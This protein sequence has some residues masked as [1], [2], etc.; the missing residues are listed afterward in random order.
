MFDLSAGANVALEEHFD[1]TAPTQTVYGTSVNGNW[2]IDEGDTTLFTMAIGLGADAPDAIWDALSAQ[3]L[4]LVN[5]LY[6]DWTGSYLPSGAAVD[7]EVVVGAI[8]GSIPNVINI[9]SK[10]T[11]MLGIQET[12]G[13]NSREYD[14]Y[15]HQML[16]KLP[17]D[18]TYEPIG[19]LLNDYYEDVV[20]GIQGIGLPQ[21]FVDELILRTEINIF[22]LLM[23][24]QIE[25][26]SVSALEIIQQFVPSTLHMWGVSATGPDS[27]PAFAHEFGV[28][29]ELF[30]ELLTQ[31]IAFPCTYYV[32]TDFSFEDGYDGLMA[33]ATTQSGGSF[34]EDK[35]N[36][37]LDNYSVDQWDIVDKS[38][39]LS[40]K[41]NGINDIF[42]QT[43]GLA[44]GF[45]AMLQNIENEFGNVFT[46]DPATVW[47]EVT[48]H[49]QYDVDG[50]LYNLHLQSGWGI[51]TTDNEKLEFLADFDISQG[52]HDTGSE[53]FTGDRGLFANIPGYETGLMLVAAFGAIVFL[54][55]RKRK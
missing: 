3:M 27:F 4:T 40:W 1:G 31:G 10:V 50:K 20:A 15:V 2:G 14:F 52:E 36:D 21:D 6:H 49:W 37:F 34:T 11:D 39:E 23:D 9:Q 32:P 16:A 48:F 42:F 54:Y 8:L 51:K 18:P 25:G 38:V 19:M 47:A 41:V 43:T 30:P 44:P 33:Y 13:V 55:L 28:V 29:D 45:T 24:T 7:A 53:N 12:D 5:D 17:D 35:L 22:E 26:T 46:F